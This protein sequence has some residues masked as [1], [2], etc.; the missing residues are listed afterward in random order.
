MQ[1]QTFRM[2]TYKHITYG[3]LDYPIALN[4]KPVRVLTNESLPKLLKMWSIGE[5]DTILY[6]F[7]VLTLY[8]GQ[9]AIF[10]GTGKC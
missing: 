8:I 10:K 6:L 3:P 4:G 7:G 9:L 2:L 1:S 5:E